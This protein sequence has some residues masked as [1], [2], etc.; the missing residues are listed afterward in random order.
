MEWKFY[1]LGAGATAIALVALATLWWTAMAGQSDPRR[2]ISFESPR[3]DLARQED[4]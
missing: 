1:T 3:G 2:P 4:R